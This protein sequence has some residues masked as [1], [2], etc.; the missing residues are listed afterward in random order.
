MLRSQSICKVFETNPVPQSP[1]S[2]DTPRSTPWFDYVVRVSPHHTDYGGIVWHGT[3]LSWMEEARVEQLRWAGLEYHNLVE[4]GCE[5]PVVELNIRYHQ[6][7]KMGMQVVVKSRIL[8]TKGVRIPWEYRIE[9]LE[10]QSHYLSAQV[11]LAP[12]DGQTGK[13]MR[14]LPPVLQTSLAQMLGAS[15]L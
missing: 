2:K 6:P 4:M 11:T 9:S 5:L 10:G 8:P 3:Y 1:S 14:R 15:T 7:V 13:I 12:I